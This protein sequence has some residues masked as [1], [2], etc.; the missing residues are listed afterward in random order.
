[1][2]S[3]PVLNLNT[4][5]KSLALSPPIPP[6]VLCFCFLSK[7]WDIIWNFVCRCKMDSEDTS[8][9][10]QMTVA[11]LL[12]VAVGASIIAIAPAATNLYAPAA[13]RPL[14]SQ[15]AVIKVPRIN[16]GSVNT[17]TAQGCVGI[18]ATQRVVFVW[19]RRNFSVLIWVL[20]C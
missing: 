8:S 6:P 13:V 19:C 10:G 17:P 20:V 15:V 1:M 9:T 18:P 4:P 16:L 5:P 7:L 11:A 2:R 12:G 3:L 14:F